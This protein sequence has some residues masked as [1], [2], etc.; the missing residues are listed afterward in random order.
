MTA[1]RKHEQDDPDRHCHVCPVYVRERAR[2]QGVVRGVSA[3]GSHPDMSRAAGRHLDTDAGEEPTRTVRE[4]KFA[5]NPSLASRANSGIH[6][7]Q[8]GREPGQPDVSLRP[9]GRERSARRRMTAVAE[10]TNHEVAR[11]ARTANGHREQHRVQAGHHRHPGVFGTRTSGMP[12]AA[13]VIAARPRLGPVDGQR[14]LH[15]GRCPQ[16]SPLVQPTA[17]KSTVSPPPFPSFGSLII[18]PAGPFIVTA[19]S[20]LCPPWL[21]FLPVAA[22]ALP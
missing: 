22:P 11:R 15:H 5:G 20:G 18:P 19:A 9:G 1:R 10:S 7:S 3:C 2:C 13:S 4:R 21:R 6:V 8:R 16:P 12:R 17:Q 14:P